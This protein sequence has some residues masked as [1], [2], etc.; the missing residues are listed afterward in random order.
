MANHIQRT[1]RRNH[2]GAI[3]HNILEQLKIPEETYQDIFQEFWSPGE[4]LSRAADRIRSSSLDVSENNT[5]SPSNT[6]VIQQIQSETGINLPDVSRS[7]RILIESLD[8]KLSRITS[9]ETDLKQTEEMITD[10][11]TR[12]ERLANDLNE[13]GAY[14]AGRLPEGQHVFFSN[15]REMLVDKLI[16]QD[17]HSKLVEHRKLVEQVHNIRPIVRTLVVQTS[18]HGDGTSVICKI[19]MESPIRYTLDPCGHCYCETCSVRASSDNRCF[20]CRK[21]IHKILRLFM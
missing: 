1:L 4:V 2:I 7:V 17:A 8:D 12:I 15:L 3:S 19:C 14:T 16:Q 18:G 9:L 20:Q 5:E 11:N 21:A 6:R 13:I 10:Y